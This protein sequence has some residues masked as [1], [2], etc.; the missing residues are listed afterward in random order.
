MQLKRPVPGLEPLVQ[1]SA[2]NLGAAFGNEQANGAKGTTL[3]ESLDEILGPVFTGKHSLGDE[4]D[5][6]YI[7]GH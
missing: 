3:D 1:E 4:D 2:C 7:S 6:D 5:A